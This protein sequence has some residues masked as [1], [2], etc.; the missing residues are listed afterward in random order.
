MLSG[1]A[2]GA[3]GNTLET[4][5]R[6]F[7]EL[8]RHILATEKYKRNP[9][10]VNTFYEKRLLYFG[11]GEGLKMV[12][13]RISR[14]G[15]NEVQLPELKFDQRVPGH[16]DNIIYVHRCYFHNQPPFVDGPVERFCL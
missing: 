12:R 3:T 16:I 9:A 4:I 2:C 5:E 14:N 6:A 1:G 13:E 11:L 15:A 7:A 8:Y 10:P